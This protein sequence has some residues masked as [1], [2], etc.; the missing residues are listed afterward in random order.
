MYTGA[1]ALRNV[2]RSTRS[3]NTIM[4]DCMEQ[5]D[6]SVGDLFTCTAA[7]PLEWF[8]GDARRR[9][10]FSEGWRNYV[11]ATAHASES[12]DNLGLIGNARM[13]DHGCRSWT[14]RAFNRMALP[15]IAASQ[16][17]CPARPGCSS[18]TGKKNP[19][20][21]STAI[22]PTPDRDGGGLVLQGYGRREMIDVIVCRS[23]VKLPALLDLVS[24]RH[25]AALTE[26]A[27]DESRGQT[28]GE[29]HA[30]RILRF[31]PA[32]GAGMKR[33]VKFI[34]YLPEYGWSLTVLTVRSVMRHLRTHRSSRNS[35]GSARIPHVHSGEHIQGR[36]Q[37]RIRTY[38]SCRTGGDRIA[39]IGEEGTCRHIQDV[40]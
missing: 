13:A 35:F 23:S 31:P 34:Q 7:R 6:P 36:S 16:G 40:G 37:G 24:A 22:P 28:D 1:P 10:T 20:D 12:C 27:V 33:L 9:Q 19:R 5:N 8:D 11:V 17:C 32:G 4:V 38:R 29:E 26:E 14:W 25:V 18:G 30:G 39:D 21:P 3:H 15:R 2:F